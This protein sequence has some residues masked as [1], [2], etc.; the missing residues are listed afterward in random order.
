MLVSENTGRLKPKVPGAW[1]PNPLGDT[2]PCFQDSWFFLANAVK[3]PTNQQ[4]TLASF[5]CLWVWP[6]LMDSQYILL[7]CCGRWVSLC[8]KLS[9]HAGLNFGGGEHAG[10]NTLLKRRTGT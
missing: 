7:F 3:I 6:L 5:A 8:L 4:L 9:Q 10:D 1:N 2:S